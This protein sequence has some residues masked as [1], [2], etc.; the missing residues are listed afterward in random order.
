MTGL[1]LGCPFN[2]CTARTSPSKFLCPHHWSMVPSYLR[3]QIYAAWRNYQRD[4]RAAAGELRA[5]QQD[6][7]EAIGGK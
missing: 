7:L 5:A 6:A 1:D 2:G 4:P 3:V